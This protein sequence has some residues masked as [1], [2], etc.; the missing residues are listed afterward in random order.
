MEPSPTDAASV[1]AYGADAPQPPRSDFVAALLWIAFG[2]AIAIASW[3][4]D[5]LQNQDINPYTIPG[6]L[7]GLLGVAI[8]FFGALL[9]AR[10]WRAGALDAHGRGEP[11][12]MSAYELKRFALIVALCLAFGIGLVGHGL[13]FWVAAALYVAA[14]IATLQYPQRKAAGQVA[15]GIVVAIVIGVCAGY[16]ITLVFQDI[17]LVR[18]P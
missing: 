2:V 18:L 17:F 10:A 14:T 9:L 4:M 5:R 1:P 7:P 8:V 12:R 15:R 3:R 16:A 11:R 13:P 6:L